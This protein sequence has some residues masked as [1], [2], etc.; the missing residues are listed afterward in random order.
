[1]GEVTISKEDRLIIDRANQLKSQV[2]KAS[3][4]LAEAATQAQGA[5]PQEKEQENGPKKA[6]KEAAEKDDSQFGNKRKRK[7]KRFGSKE[8]WRPL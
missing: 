1:M 4:K 6:D 7:F 3:K 2:E 5:L 8:N